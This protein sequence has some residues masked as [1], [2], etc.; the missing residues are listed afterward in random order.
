MYIFAS[1]SPEIQYYDNSIEFRNIKGDLLWDNHKCST[2]N[3]ELNG[4]TF[5]W[6]SSDEYLPIEFTYEFIQTL[7]VPIITNKEIKII[8]NIT[9]VKFLIP[10]HINKFL[11][12]FNFN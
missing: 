2:I 8:D 5:K 12:N 10:I 6:N 9:Y 1:N 3:E 7:S 4:I 11:D